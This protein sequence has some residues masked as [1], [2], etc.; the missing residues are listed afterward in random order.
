M[1]SETLSLVLTVFRSA[2][3]FGAVVDR[4]ARF[5]MVEEAMQD[6]LRPIMDAFEKAAKVLRMKLKKD[7][8]SF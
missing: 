7:I 3:E 4:C 5:D 2:T 8:W 6:Q 1:H